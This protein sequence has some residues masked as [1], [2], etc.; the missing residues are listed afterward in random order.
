MKEIGLIIL[1]WLLGIFSGPINDY[2]QDKRKRKSIKKGIVI[3]LKELQRILA[4]VCHTFSARSGTLNRALIDKLAI[5]FAQYKGD[6][7]AEEFGKKYQE[8]KNLTDSQLKE[9]LNLMKANPGIAKTVGPISLP[10]LQ[11]K[12]SDLVVFSE[13]N[14][15]LAL[16]LINHIKIYNEI[17][18]HCSYFY[19]LTFDNISSDNHK[20]AIYE[21]EQGYKR[22]GDR[23]EYVIDKINEFLKEISI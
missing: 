13:K 19:K 15:Q 9:A 16:E 2:F 7:N 21:Q 1:G 11:S 3:E 10:Y 23:S 8:Y 6:T 22:I 20:I 14:Q 12:I 4:S 17:V 5:I 18:D